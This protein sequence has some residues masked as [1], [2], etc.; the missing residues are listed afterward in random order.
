MKTRVTAT[1]AARKFSEI[2]NRVA[3]KGETFVVERGGRPVCEIA[4]A[5]T[6]K[7]TAS[8]FAEMIKSAPRPDDEYFDAVE[9]V[10]KNRQPVAPS[11][12]RR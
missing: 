11:P 7:F 3:Y 5:H 6:K 10:I 9:E 2:L 12:W 4:P 1:E 8:D